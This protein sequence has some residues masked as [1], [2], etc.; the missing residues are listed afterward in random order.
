M[1]KPLSLFWSKNNRLFFIIKQVVDKN[2]PG[3]LYYILEK[4]RY[5]IIS[6]YPYGSANNQEERVIPP[7]FLPSKRLTL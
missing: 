5:S 2:L 6:I 4:G 7:L 3:S 1:M